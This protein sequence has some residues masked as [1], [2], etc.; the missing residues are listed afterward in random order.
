[1]SRSPA[2]TTFSTGQNFRSKAVHKLL[3]GLFLVRDGLDELE[4]GAAAI[5]VVAGT[6]DAEVCVAYQ[7]IG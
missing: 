2:G 6:M 4:L 3:H 5:E 7:E 1:M